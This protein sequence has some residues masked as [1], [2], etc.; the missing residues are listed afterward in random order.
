LL[1]RA[2]GKAVEGFRDDAVNDTMMIVPDGA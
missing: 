1:F 2:V